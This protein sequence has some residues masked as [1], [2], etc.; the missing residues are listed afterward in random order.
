M[1]KKHDLNISTILK[2]K[3]KSQVFFMNNFYKISS[4][5]WT[6]LPYSFKS[7]HLLKF[8]SSNCFIL[9]VV[10]CDAKNKNQLFTL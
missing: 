1:V 6:I 10:Y 7:K 8:L 4:N 2:A 3:K 9:P 5:S